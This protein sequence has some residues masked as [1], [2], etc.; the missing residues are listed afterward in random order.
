MVQYLEFSDTPRDT[1]QSWYVMGTVVK[2]ALS[3]SPPSSDLQF[4]VS[5]PPVQMGLR[6]SILLRKYKGLNRIIHVLNRSR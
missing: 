2:L 3:V 1:A 6:M 4:R 5:N